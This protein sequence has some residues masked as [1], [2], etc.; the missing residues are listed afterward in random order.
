MKFAWREIYILPRITTI[1]TYLRPYQYKIL[2]NIS[3]FFFRM[4]NTPLCSC[5]NE[6]GETPSHIFSECTSAIYLKQKLANFLK[7]TWFYHHLHH[8]ANHDEPIINHFLLIF[9]LH[10]YNWREKHRLNIMNLLTNIKE[11]KKTEYSLSFNRKKRKI[12]I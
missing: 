2:N 8:N 5:C 3:F 12:Y 10:V 6:E 9:K 1:N 7:T 11:I 4:K